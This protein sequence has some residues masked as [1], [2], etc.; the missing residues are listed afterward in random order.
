MDQQDY[1]DLFKKLLPKGPAWSQSDQGTMNEI[2]QAVGDFF[3]YIHDRTEKALR[4]MHPETCDETLLDW[5]KEFGLPETCIHGNHAEGL[6]VADRV[7]QIIAKI[8]RSFSPTIENF[9]KLAQSLG[10]DI[11]IITTPPAICGLARCGDRL[12]GTRSESY[13]MISIVDSTRISYARAGSARC[14]DHLCTITFATDLECL[15]NRIKQ[16]HTIFK[17]SYLQ[18]E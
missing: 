8:N 14:G 15:F 17:F 18:G 3:L 2:A 11:N 10:Y 4:E 16:A 12:G 1:T 6:T 13:Y 7:Q 5:E 9:A